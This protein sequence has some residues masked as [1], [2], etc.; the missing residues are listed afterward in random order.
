MFAPWHQRD[1][2]WPIQHQI[3]GTF[4]TLS[5]WFSASPC[6]RYQIEAFSA[7]LAIYEGHPPVTSGF[8]SQRPVTWSFDLRLSK[9]LSKQTKR[10]WYETPLR[11]LWPH[12]NG[13]DVRQISFYDGKSLHRNVSTVTMLFVLGLSTNSMTHICLNILTNISSD[14]VLSPGRRQAIIRNNIVIWTIGNKLQWNLYR[15][16]IHENTF[17]NVV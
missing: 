11:S 16:F 1:I 3:S 12:C 6:W 5:R 7:L 8:P 4:C 13:Y 9:R 17:E 14:N 15:N 2:W 10:W